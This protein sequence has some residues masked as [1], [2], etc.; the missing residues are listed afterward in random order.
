MMKLEDIR[1]VPAVGPSHR[2]GAIHQSAKGAQTVGGVRV[3][4]R[5]GNLRKKSAVSSNTAYSGWVIEYG[6]VEDSI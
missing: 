6:A 2:R 1:E 4:R 3:V 5:Q